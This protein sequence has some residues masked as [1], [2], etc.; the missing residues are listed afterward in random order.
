MR[1][2]AGDARGRHIATLSGDDTRPTL[3]R[4]KE[5]MFSS[6]QFWLPGATVLDVFAGSG[7][8]GLEALSRGASHCVFI[9]ENREAAALIRRNAEAIGLSARCTILRTSAEAYLARDGGRRFD[10]A[11]LDPPYHSGLLAR[12]LPALGDVLA[13]RA[14]VLCESEADFAPPGEAGR[15]LLA[16]QYRHGSVLLARYET[17]G[18]SAG[19]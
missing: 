8:L 2:I 14:I 16:K 10:L 9:D 5:A 11:L 1:I 6:V 4:V 13:Q 12:V 7:Q 19:G 15:L 3:E 17:A 18:F